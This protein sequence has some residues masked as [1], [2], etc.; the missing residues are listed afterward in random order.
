MSDILPFLLAGRPVISTETLPVEDKY[1]RRPVARVS[2]PSAADVEEALAAAERAE[3]TMREL[4]GDV[5]R[6]ILLHCARTIDERRE[7]FMSLIVT[8]SGK[9]RRD[10]RLEVERAIG[11][12]TV[13]AEEVLR[14]PGEILD[15]GDGPR[16]RGTLAFTRRFPRGA[17]LLVTPFNFPLN[18]VAH[19]V[20]PAIAAGCPFILKPSEKTPLT[21]L[22]LGEILA[23]SA[24]PAEGYSILPL[25][26]ERTLRLV[27]DERLRIFS[28]TGGRIGWKLR[29]RAG[30]KKVLLE[31][32]GN[33]A[34]IVDAD[35][36]P[37][38]PT[39]V[40]KLVRGAFAQ[41]GE[42]CISVQR[43]LVHGSLYGELRDRLVEAARRLRVGDPADEHTDLGPLIDVEAAR[44]L[45]EWI[46]EACATGARILCGG[47]GDDPLMPA[48]VLEDVTHDCRLW[49]EEAF[50]PIAVLEHFEDFERALESVNDSSY[51]LQAGLFSD[52]LSHIRAAWERLEVGGVIVGETP[53]FRVDAMPYGGV[54]LSGSGREGLRYAIEEM[55]ERRL[56]VLH[57]DVATTS[58]DR[59]ASQQ[60]RP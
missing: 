30:H 42:S 43:I 13:A 3:S 46:E 60:S 18:L 40:Q 1:R 55:S 19:K 47:G 32:G 6:E 44:R 12:F 45:R 48:T 39:I 29:E 16:T 51:G 14:D 25:P 23:S 28:F 21:A 20:A 36:G 49:R 57:P 56:L 54:K 59:S 5:R 35:Q 41:S 17:A 26:A 50:G 2:L 4:P 27:E 31:L 58:M 15:L 22:R 53:N 24:L 34:C 37:R 11:T 38:L 7:E 33:A 52:S 9:P 8:E 10:A